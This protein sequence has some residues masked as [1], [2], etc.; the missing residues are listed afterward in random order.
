MQTKW[1]VAKGLAATVLCASVT[2]GALAA[3]VTYTF[4][5]TGPITGSLG[6][7]AIGGAGELLTFTF[8]GDTSKV[9]SFASPVPGH[10]I[11][12]G[13]SAISVTDISTG[14]T[15][16]SGTFLPTDGI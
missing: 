4:T 2:V 14:V 3:P 7:V 11:L 15:V 16:A 9:M 1:S 5:A 8:A 12:L 6:A 10:E 13:T